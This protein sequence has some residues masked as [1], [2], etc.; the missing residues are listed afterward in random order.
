MVWE[1]FVVKALE[2]GILKPFHPSLAVGKGLEA[3]QMGMNKNEKGV[4]FAKVVVEL[5]C[6]RQ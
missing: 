6:F 2:R 4:S 3:L 1:R 5:W